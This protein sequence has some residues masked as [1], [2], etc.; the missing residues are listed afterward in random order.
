MQKEHV[1]KLIPTMEQET[2]DWD[3]VHLRIAKK[4]VDAQVLAYV[5]ARAEQSG[6]NT[7]YM[8]EATAEGLQVPGIQSVALVAEEQHV[9]EPTAP[10][11]CDFHVDSSSDNQPKQ[12]AVGPPVR[13]SLAACDVWPLRWQLILLMEPKMLPLQE[14]TLHSDLLEVPFTLG[15]HIRSHVPSILWK[16]ARLHH[17]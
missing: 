14:V 7:A 4:Q 8:F 3:A 10:T 16:M 5:Q 11:P 15:S 6:G 9:P 1:K 2:M 12:L 13:S 17:T